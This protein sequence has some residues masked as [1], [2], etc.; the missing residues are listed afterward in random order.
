MALRIGS[1][2]VRGVVRITYTVTSVTVAAE[3]LSDL[4][5][6]TPPPNWQEGQWSTLNGWPTA[7]RLHEGR[8]WWAGQ[9]GVW[10]SISDAYESLRRDDRGQRRP[11]QPHDRLG[12]VD[13]S[14]GS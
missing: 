7:V 2:S 8:L 5:G 13:T 10:G 12:P 11:D 4:G 6:T 9:N 3:V 14:T 1:G